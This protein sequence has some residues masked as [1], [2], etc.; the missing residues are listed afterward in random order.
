ML[1]LNGEQDRVYW[2][3]IQNV[4]MPTIRVVVQNLACSIHFKLF[5][6][7]NKILKTFKT[8]SHHERNIFSW[9]F[10]VNC[11]GCTNDTINMHNFANCRKKKGIFVYVGHIYFSHAINIKLLPFN[12]FFF[13]KHVDLRASI[14]KALCSLCRNF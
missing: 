14:Y 8:I 5:F 7:I 9:A 10:S 6:E 3:S 11:C 4:N 13:W 12:S 1:W 2:L